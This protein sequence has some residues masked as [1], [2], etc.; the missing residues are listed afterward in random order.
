MLI[1]RG[2]PVSIVFISVYKWWVSPRDRD[3]IGL[4]G[5]IF[6]G[7]YWLGGVFIGVLVEGFEPLYFQGYLWGVSCPVG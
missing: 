3:R 1:D 7:G 2:I 5:G 6:G 4:N